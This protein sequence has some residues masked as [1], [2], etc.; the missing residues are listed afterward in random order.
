MRG[1]GW[2]LYK[3][4]NYYYFWSVHPEEWSEEYCPVFGDVGILP[5]GGQRGGPPSLLCL[6]F[7]I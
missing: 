2:K 6:D 1:G 7:K 4:E 3:F 5:G